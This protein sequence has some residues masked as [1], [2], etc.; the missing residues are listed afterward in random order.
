MELKDLISHIFDKI[1]IFRDNGNGE[2]INLYEGT[3]TEIPSEMLVL[4]VGIIGAI[5]KGVIDIEV[6]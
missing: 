6:R 4:K 3:T 1:V 2:Y 5:R